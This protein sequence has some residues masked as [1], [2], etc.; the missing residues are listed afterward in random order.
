MNIIQVEAQTLQVGDLVLSVH[1]KPVKIK[2]ISAG[3]LTDTL[4]FKWDNG[5]WVNVPF[6]RL[7][8]RVD[9]E[10]FETGSLKDVVMELVRCAKHERTVYAHSFLCGRPNDAKASIEADN[11]AAECA[12]QQ[13][14]FDRVAALILK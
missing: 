7:I 3:S 6:D 11:V 4:C 2:E 1:D 5:G 10:N 9:V 12:A 13:R 8:D 14:D